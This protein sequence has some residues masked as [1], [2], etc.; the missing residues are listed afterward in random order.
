ME[1][2]PQSFYD[3]AKCVSM[4]VVCDGKSQ[5][6]TAISHA[7]MHAKNDSPIEYMLLLTCVICIFCCFFEPVHSGT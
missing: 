5:R 2:T 7:F 3:V 1:H 6:T 4:Y